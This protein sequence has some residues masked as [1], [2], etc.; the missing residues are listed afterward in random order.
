MQR[1]SLTAANLLAGSLLPLLATPVEK[2]NIIVILVDDL[3]YAD[4]S[5]QR[6]AT[7]IQ[8][9]HIDKLLDE[10]IRFTNFYANCPVSSPSR[11]SL[12]TGKFPDRVGVPGVIRTHPED[13]WGYLSPEAILLPEVLKQAGYHSALIGKWHLGLKTPNTPSGTGF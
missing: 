8:T 1:Y 3:G 5:C 11:A 9:P 4:L 13:S 2:P 6:V 7:D 12:L 10:G